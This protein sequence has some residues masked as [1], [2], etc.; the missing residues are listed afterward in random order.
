M[1][2]L[3]LAK[4]P[5]FHARTKHVELDYH[6]VCEKFIQGQLILRYIQSLLQ[7]IYVLKK[8]LNVW[9]SS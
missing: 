4:N 1:R 8:S 3:H 5:V 7:I 9:K 6:F 2:A